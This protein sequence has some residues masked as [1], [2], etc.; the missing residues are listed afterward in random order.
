MTVYSADKSCCLWLICAVRLIAYPLQVGHEHARQV[1]K[2]EV[3]EV[4]D[5]IQRRRFECMLCACLSWRTED[6][7]W[8]WGG[9]YDIDKEGC[10]KCRV[11]RS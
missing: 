6:S 4:M 8:E 2:G 5:F 7:E 9:I 1:G 3:V 10:Q 11:G